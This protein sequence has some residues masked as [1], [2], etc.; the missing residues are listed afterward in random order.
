MKERKT[1]PVNHR[2]SDD[3]AGQTGWQASDVEKIIANPLY[4]GFGPVEAL[5]P[6]ADWI[7][8]ASKMIRERGPERFLLL[9][10]ENLREAFGYDGEVK[11]PPVP[12]APP[13][14]HREK[15]TPL[16]RLMAEAKEGDG[17]LII[18]RP[19]VL[20]DNYE[21]LITNLAMIAKAELQ[22]VIRSAL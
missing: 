21:E 22:L 15:F 1:R 9:L 19:S 13:V 8:A 11:R 7:S 10:L 12:P 20:G 6:T 3:V 16:F 17:T 4:A 18:D 2:P 14:N 5:L